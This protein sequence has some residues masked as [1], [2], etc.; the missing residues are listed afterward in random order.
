SHAFH[1][2]MMDPIVEP[3]ANYCRKVKFSAPKIP[4]VSTVTPQWITPEIVTNP[5]YWAK[6][7][8]AT[9]RFAEGIQT[10]WQDPS[11][12][13]LEV[14]PRI[15]ATTLARQQAKDTKQQIAIASLGST[16]DDEGEWTALLQAVGKLWLAG[17]D[18]D[19]KSFYAKENRHRIALPTY[20]FER[21]R[22]WIDPKPSREL[23][24]SPTQSSQTNNFTENTPIQPMSDSRKQRLIPMLKEVLEN[25][26]G[27]DIDSADNETTFLEIGL[28]SL[29]LT[30]VALALKKK[31]KV[32][33]TFRHLMEDCPNLDTLADFIDNSLPA[34]AFP[35]PVAVAAT[36]TPAA[37]VA[38]TQPVPSTPIPTPMAV[39]SMSFNSEQKNAIESL[40][41]QQL[42]IMSQQLQILG[43]GGATLAPLPAATA[44][45]APT[46]ALSTASSPP[47]EPPKTETETPKP[48]KSFG[49]GAKIDKSTDNNLTSEQQSYLDKFIA[50]YTN[51]TQESKRQ[52]QGHR[53][54]LADPRTVSGFSLP[55]KEIVYPIVTDRSSGSKLW[56]VDG[57]EYIDLTNGF[58]LNFFG[59]SPP[60]VTEAIEAQLKKGMEIGPQTP[61]A[62]KVAKLLT[63]FTGQE[64]VAFCNTGSE[65]VM[66]AMRLART[67]TGRNTIAIFSGAYHG[68]FDEVIVRGSPKLKSF[69]AAPGIM[70]SMFENVLVLDYGTPESLE[71]LRE[72][73]DELAA[74]MVEPVQSRRPE[75]QPKDFLQE[76]R[77]ITER[78]ETAFIFDEVVT[79]FRVHPGGAQAYFGIKADIATYGKVI[80]GGLP[81]GVVAGKSEFMDALDG[82]HWQFGDESFPEVG[83]TFF[84]GT[85]V[86][87]PLA[88]AAS[89]AVLERLKEAGPELQRSLSK[90]VDNFVTELKQHLEKVQAPI[91]VNHFSSFFY[92]HYPPEV[93]YG[94]LLF[95]LLREKGV[96]IWEHRPCFFTLAHSDADI[97]FVMKAFKE[98]VAQMQEL[99]FL[100]K[101]SGGNGHNN[102]AG[103]VNYAISDRPPQPGAKLGKDPQGNPAWYIPDPER[104]GK[105]LQ[106]GA[107]IST[108]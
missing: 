53:K 77:R 3:F 76:I 43:Q 87:H 10:I 33:I 60:F 19:W 80:G 29:S 39:P 50:Q 49:P 108:S 86:R 26:S 18:L 45:T 69:P 36:P 88:L 92:V 93:T 15:T 68:T 72:R 2:P 16:A 51:K 6:H 89:K 30:Q 17:I 98:S 107:A 71:I 75:L 58:G 32:K 12:V 21:K 91:E 27:L 20:P 35:A 62:G 78:S 22:F 102:G 11:R 40:V 64:R 23:P 55:L 14:G 106:I 47:S 24:A 13:L 83:V 4:F 104:P 57:N 7:L 100:P 65:A 42:Q 37:P 101:P 31:F 5:Q 67:V 85:F 96:H 52:T 59:W 99:G 103:E 84:A 74:I 105:Y 66:A 41:A 44:A 61:L 8:R 28:D 25:T 94:G 38:P 34:D 54:Y 9:V 63:E 81:I 56:D 1:S 70:P 97:E 90:K 79:G 46:P 95:Y 48:K 73:A 82:G